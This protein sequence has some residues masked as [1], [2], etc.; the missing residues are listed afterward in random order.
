MWEEEDR[1]ACKYTPMTQEELAEPLT[2]R[3]PNL[4]SNAPDV[5]QALWHPLLAD[6]ER[7]Y[8]WWMLS[9]EELQTVIADI[10]KR[11]E[12]TATSRM[13]GSTPKQQVAIKKHKPAAQPK[14]TTSKSGS[15]GST[16]PAKSASPASP[17]NQGIQAKQ[18]LGLSGEPKEPPAPRLQSSSGIREQSKT[19]RN[20]RKIRNGMV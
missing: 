11:A 19:S 8:A 1:K 6:S 17:S 4:V 10:Q 12:R 16:T 9:Q 13:T 20:C 15:S 14:G 18:E 3:S 7:A 2:P 5:G